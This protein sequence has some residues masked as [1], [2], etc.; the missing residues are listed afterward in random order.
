MA[1]ICENCNAEF[2]QTP[3]GKQEWLLHRATHKK[4]T[5][6]TEPKG[7]K[8]MSAKEI[9]QQQA[10]EQ[11]T[12]KPKKA[13]LSYRWEGEC[14]TCFGVLDSIMIEAGQEKGKVVTVAFCTHCKNEVAHRQVDK[15]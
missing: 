11:K 2:E 14:P 7:E 13:T 5:A 4:G 8:S 9:K 12:R 1:F 6:P 10:E 15:L 3:K